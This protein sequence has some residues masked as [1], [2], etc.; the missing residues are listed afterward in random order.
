M[1]TI[2]W[3]S[4]EQAHRLV[5]PT[6]QFLQLTS[7]NYFLTPVASVDNCDCVSCPILAVAGT[8]LAFPCVCM[9]IVGGHV[10]HHVSQSRPQL[11]WCMS[12]L[13][14]PIQLHLPEFHRPK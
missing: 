3:L 10:H 7:F 5:D 12:S 1:H 11:A 6:A 4:N 2:L 14:L 8:G 13:H 9:Y